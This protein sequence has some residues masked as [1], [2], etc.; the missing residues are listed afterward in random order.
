MSQ[1]HALV[2]ARG[3]AFVGFEGRE[4]RI[5]LGDEYPA[6]DPLV[7]AF[8]SLFGPPP[9]VLAAPVA[10]GPIP[11]GTP[12][13]PVIDEPQAPAPIAPEPTDEDEDEVAPAA[14]R[15]RARRRAEPAAAAE[16]AGD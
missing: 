2:R 3:T 4:I 13:A 1:P 11:E 9:T 6:D 15:R 7:L 5:G 12:P 10:E 14:P 16:P 8:P